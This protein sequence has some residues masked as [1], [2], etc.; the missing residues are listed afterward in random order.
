MTDFN[1]WAH[2]NPT[3]LPLCVLIHC[4]DGMVTVSLTTRLEIC[5]LCL[6]MHPYFNVLLQHK[7]KLELKGEWKCNRRKISAYPTLLFGTLNLML[8]TPENHL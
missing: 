5:L 1:R 2:L 6:F 8:I 3:C 7:L 4:I